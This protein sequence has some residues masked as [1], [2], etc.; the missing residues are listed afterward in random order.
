M[1]MAEALRATGDSLECFP[2][3]GRLVPGTGKRELVSVS[4][5]VIR[6]RVEGDEVR[7]LRVRHSARRPT[8]P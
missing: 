1:H 2:H 6:Y 5:Y 3:R 7:I 8:N 4:P